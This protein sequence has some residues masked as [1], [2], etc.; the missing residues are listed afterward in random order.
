MDRIE[1]A[2]ATSYL[3]EPLARD[4]GIHIETF[5]SLHGSNQPYQSNDAVTLTT[6]LSHA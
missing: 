4:R 3:I 5:R 1:Y 2:S 6:H